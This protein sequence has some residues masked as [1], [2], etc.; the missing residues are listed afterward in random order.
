MSLQC[1]KTNLT[2][3]QLSQLESMPADQLADLIESTH[4]QYIRETGPQLIEMAD[5]L[6]R[7]HG[8]ESE[9][10]QKLTPLIHALVNELTPHLYKEEQILFPAIR[11]LATQ[12]PQQT[13]FGHIGNPIR[14]MTHEHNEADQIVV[15]LQQVTQNFQAPEEAC[16]TWQRCYKVCDEFCQDLIN[17]IHVEDTILFPA[18][19]EMADEA[20]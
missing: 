8:E 5:K 6:L 13:C 17:H 9:T 3:D 2:Q 19:I 11:G 7:V 10:I 4:H 12:T 16:Q 20:V 14:V 1:G 18:A 15:A